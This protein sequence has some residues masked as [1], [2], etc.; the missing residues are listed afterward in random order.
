[1][2]MKTLTAL[3]LA[4][5]L[6]AAGIA[7][8]DTPIYKWVD[9]QGKVHY[10]TE[11]HGDKPQQLAIQNS[12]TPHAGTDVTPVPGAA[13]NSYAADATLVQPQPADSP[14]CKAGRDRLFQ[15]L[16]AGTLYSVDEKGNKTTL[17]PDAMKKALDDARAYVK[18][19][20]GGGA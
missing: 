16:H 5:S 3:A 17:S 6:L 1:M 8:A 13:T 20:C 10:S 2:H 4:A 19:A 14:E 12:A 9:D 11:P 18:Q 7:H 15:Y